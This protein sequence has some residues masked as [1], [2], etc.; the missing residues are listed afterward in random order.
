MNQNLEKMMSNNY[1]YKVA[2]LDESGKIIV[3]IDDKKYGDYS[4]AI[5]IGE[6]GDDGKIEIDYDFISDNVIP[7]AVKDSTVEQ[8]VNNIFQEILQEINNEK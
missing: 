8:I 4:V 2:G 5:N 6:M 3:L 7:V 1:E